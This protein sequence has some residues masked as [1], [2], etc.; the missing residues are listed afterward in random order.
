[1][2]GEV[3][4]LDEGREQARRITGGKC[5]R[6]GVQQVQRPGGRSMLCVLRNS[7]KVS[8]AGAE[9]EEGWRGLHRCRQQT[10]EAVPG[11]PAVD[12]PVQA[13][14]PVGLLP[15]SQGPGSALLLLASLSRFSAASG[16]LSEA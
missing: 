2:D 14:G 5:L 4:D 10:A 12:L 16:D 8:V 9:G 6:P 15:L 3:R 13:G 7:K 11:K 1:M